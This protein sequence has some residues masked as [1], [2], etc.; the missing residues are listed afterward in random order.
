MHIGD[1][2]LFIW[3]IFRCRVPD[4]RELFQSHQ[5]AMYKKQKRIEKLRVRWYNQNRRM[6]LRWFGWLV[7]GTF[8]LFVYDTPAPESVYLR[9]EINT[10]D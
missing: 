8:E 9:F 10:P 3:S 5:Y 4:T 2:F 7:M 1:Q 6:S